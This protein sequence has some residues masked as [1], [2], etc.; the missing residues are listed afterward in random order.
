MSVEV[1]IT[2]DSYRDELTIPVGAVVEHEQQNFCWVRTE[3]EFSRRLL[4]LGATNDQFMIVKSGVKEGDEVI[5]N[6]RAHIEEARLDALKP[7]IQTDSPAEPSGSG[8]TE[9]TADADDG[10]KQTQPDDAK[11]NGTTG[12]K[13]AK[14]EDPIAAVFRTADKN[15]DGFLTLNEY[16]EEHKQHFP[17]QDTNQDDR[18]SLEE[19]KA[20][21]Q[22]AR[23]A[24]DG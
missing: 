13:A 14:T 7:V 8:S 11:A 12:H 18:V 9:E 22:K 4:D 17:L 23:Q 10:G 21:L 3:S 2:L 5:I 15:S 24:Q 19:L 20:F 1:E 16:A 6:P